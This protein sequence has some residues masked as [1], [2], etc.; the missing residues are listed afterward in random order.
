MLLQLDV[1]DGADYQDEHVPSQADRCRCICRGPHRSIMTRG[2]GKV[3]SCDFVAA[4]WTPIVLTK[5]A[6]LGV[7]KDDNI[8]DYVIPHAAY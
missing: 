8:C 6:K 4:H 2:A 7:K 1:A 3:A 5:I